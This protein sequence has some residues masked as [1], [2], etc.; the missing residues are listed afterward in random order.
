M[1]LM[2][3]NI[4]PFTF[5]LCISIGLGSHVS[6]IRVIKEMLACCLWLRV[7][8]LVEMSPTSMPTTSIIL[9]THQANHR[10]GEV[11]FM[12]EDRSSFVTVSISVL[13]LLVDSGIEVDELV[14][15]TL[16]G[17]IDLVSSTIP[18]ESLYDEPELDF[19]NPRTKVFSSN[20]TLHLM[21]ICYF[22]K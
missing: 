15:I 9:T 19:N 14:K 21:M 10:V 2:S 18:I 5:P 17:M 1:H 7:Y 13:Q 12:E 11:P 6:R 22:T 20:I 3:H 16:K 4:L 8:Q